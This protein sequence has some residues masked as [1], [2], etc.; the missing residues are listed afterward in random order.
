MLVTKTPLAHP[1]L[2]ALVAEAVRSLSKLDANRLE[3][4]AL[5]CQELNRDLAQATQQAM[6]Y[7][8]RAAK[9]DMAA[10]AQ[11]LKATGAN[12]A[13]MKR[14]REL[15]TNRMEYIVVRESPAMEGEVLHGIH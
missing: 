5:S 4:L 6:S 9:P 12:A 3:E 8:A 11:V 14:L 1:E 15:R 2:K 7:E 13:V 10:L